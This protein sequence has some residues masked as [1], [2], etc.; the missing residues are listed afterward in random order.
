MENQNDRLLYHPLFPDRNAL[1]AKRSDDV[2]IWIERF[3]MPAGIVTEDEDRA[4]AY[5]VVGG[6][7][8]LMRKVCEKIDKG[9]VFVGVNRGTVG[10]LLNPI[11]QINDIPLVKSQLNTFEL[12]LIKVTFTTK[13]GEE[14]SFY[15]FNDVI[16]GG[17]IADYISFKIT[18]SLNHFPER[19]VSGN[20]IVIATPQGTTGFALKARGSSAIL[21]LD[22][23]NWYIAGV[24]TGPYPCDQ[25][26]LQ[27]IT[28]DLNSRFQINGYADGRSQTV[29]D[30][31]RVIVN[32]TDKKAT[33]GILANIDFATRRTL[34]AQKVERGGDMSTSIL[35]YQLSM[36]EL[37]KSIA[38]KNNMIL[39]KVS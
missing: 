39:G 6:D 11:D 32:P 36:T 30:I 1:G 9:K 20:G 22:S 26:S 25:V 35:L 7:G 37:A 33:L 16:C 31:V 8:T 3:L 2:R 17:D 23:R 15:A 24:A 14:K 12:R 5:L 19:S 13:E 27:E 10:F 21:P 18:G 38:V 34:L 4:N 28:I 29:N